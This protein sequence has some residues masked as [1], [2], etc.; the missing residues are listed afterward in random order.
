MNNLV[1]LRQ[2]VKDGEEILKTKKSGTASFSM[3]VNSGSTTVS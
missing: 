3:T 1:K 2:L